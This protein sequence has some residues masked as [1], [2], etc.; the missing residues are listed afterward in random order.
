MDKLISCG[1][2]LLSKKFKGKDST[3][4]RKWTAVAKNLST[5]ALQKLE[6][7]YE[8]FTAQA[9]EKVLTLHH[10][11]Q[12]ALWEMSSKDWISDKIVLTESDR[13]AIELAWID[14]LLTPKSISVDSKGSKNIKWMSGDDSARTMYL[15]IL[16]T[17]ILRAVS[18]DVH[19]ILT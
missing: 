12:S 15:L 13:A 9:L 19:K 1:D 2:E 11:Y 18:I 3:A 16:R 5:T 10:L 6:S 8:E 14:K 4:L 17:K 7:A